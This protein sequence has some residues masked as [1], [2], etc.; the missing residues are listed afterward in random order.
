MDTSFSRLSQKPVILHHPVAEICTTGHFRS[1]WQVWKLFNTQSY[2]TPHQNQDRSCLSISYTMT[3]NSRRAL[4]H[5][6]THVCPIWITADRQEALTVASLSKYV[7]LVQYVCININK[8]HKRMGLHTP[9]TT[10]CNQTS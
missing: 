8:R 4:C 7:H 6:M 5:K 3:L 9:C 10:T 2:H 1:Q